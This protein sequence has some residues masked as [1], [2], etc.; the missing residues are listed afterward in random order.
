MFGALLM[1]AGA[2][3]AGL[4][5]LCS[6]VFLLSTFTGQGSDLVDA[7]GAVLALGAVPVALGLGLFFLGRG[8]WR[9]N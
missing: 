3:I 6:T 8:L 5:G 7:I 9:Q 4:S 1:A 2:L